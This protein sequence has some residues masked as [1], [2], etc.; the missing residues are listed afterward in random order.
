MKQN[1]NSEKNPNESGGQKDSKPEALVKHNNEEKVLAEAEL[2]V[3]E[4]SAVSVHDSR[5]GDIAAA[6][7][8]RGTLWGSR[9]F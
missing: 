8:A 1:E 9:L 5:D 4:L 6:S 3:P 7:L 2:Y